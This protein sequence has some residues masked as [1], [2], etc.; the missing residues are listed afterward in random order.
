MDLEPDILV[1]TMIFDHPWIYSSA[2]SA[3]PTEKGIHGKRLPTRYDFAFA[4]F[5]HNAKITIDGES[6][7]LSPM[8]V[9]ASPR[10]ACRTHILPQELP[11]VLDIMVYKRKLSS[12]FMDQLGFL[13]I[14]L[15]LIL[16]KLSPVCELPYR[17]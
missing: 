13:T 10:S 14:S 8:N 9:S 7:V 4:P 5:N 11:R 3:L 12:V 17:A 15:I 1:I 6:S 16:I 2:L